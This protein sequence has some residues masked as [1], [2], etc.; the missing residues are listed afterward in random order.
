M[1]AVNNAPYLSNRPKSFVDSA[2]V[3]LKLDSGDTL[4]AHSALLSFHSD[5][6]S[7]MLSLSRSG[8]SRVQVLPFP[9]CTL[10]AA[11]TLLKYIYAR[12]GEERITVEGAETVIVLA[13]KFGMDSILKDVDNFLADK[14]ASDGSST[15]FWGAN[16]D[17]AVHWPSVAGKNNLVR[18]AAK[19]ERFLMQA[20]G[21]L[22]D[23]PEALHLPPSLLLKM[24]DSRHAGIVGMQE[25]ARTSAVTCQR[26]HELC[27]SDPRYRHDFAAQVPKAV[28]DALARLRALEP[29]YPS[30]Q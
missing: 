26:A 20:A 29:K 6:L 16:A 8:D 15:A 4:P 11:L 1:E 23:S 9:D 24:L 28:E 21:R 22:S 5:V 7:D 19:A 3:I 10:D 13:N 2:D 27:R 30:V 12:Y 18:L 14:V 17:R 25:T